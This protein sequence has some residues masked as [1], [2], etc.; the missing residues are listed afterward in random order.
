M[1]LDRRQNIAELREVARRRLPRGVFELLDRGAEHEIAL[2][3]NRA[4]FQRI[5]LKPKV[6]VDVS[7]RSVTTTLFGKHAAMPVAIAPTGHAGLCWHDGE[8]GCRTVDRAATS[9]LSR[10][11]YMR[12]CPIL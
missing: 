7:R 5:A 3:N 4:A 1:R 12:L 2:R 10:K 11:Q 8:V 6:M 9:R